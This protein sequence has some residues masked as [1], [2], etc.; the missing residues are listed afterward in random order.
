MHVQLGPIEIQGLTIAATPRDGALPITLGATLKGDAR[1][2]DRGGR[3]RSASPRRSPSR[4]TTTATSARSTCALGFKPPNGIGLSVDAGVV[5]GGGYLFFDAERGEYAGALELSFAEFL[6]IKAIGLITTRMPD[7][8]KGFSLLIVMSV[9]FGAGHPAR[10]R[11]HAA[12]R[13]RP[14]SASTAR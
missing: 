3:E 12:R 6:S 2:A 13:R 9:E 14:A 1:A 4:R 5:R 8:S 7:G 10:L 11:L